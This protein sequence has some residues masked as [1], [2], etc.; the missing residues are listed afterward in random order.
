MTKEDLKTGMVVTYR[1]GRKSMV[2]K[3]CANN[4]FT[5][6]FREKADMLVSE[7]ATWL[8]L[9]YIDEKLFYTNRNVNDDLDII[10]V[11]CVRCPHL[12]WKPYDPKNYTVIW[13]GNPP[14]KMTVAEI[15]AILGY[16]VEIISEKES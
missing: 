11:E 14:K 13:E 3:D 10:M 1:D 12:L 7:D 6:I 15:E 9:H 5:N 4:N 8:D 16:R 2:F